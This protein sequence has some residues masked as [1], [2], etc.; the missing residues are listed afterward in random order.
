M[1]LP[2]ITLWYS[3]LGGVST[4]QID[5]LRQSKELV[6]CSQANNIIP[7]PNYAWVT[8]PGFSKVRTN[9]ISGSP[10]ITGLFHGGAL[11]DFLV[12]GNGATGDIAFDTA[13]PPVDNTSGTNF[14]T[15]Q[16]VLLRGDFHEN[17]LIITSNARDLPQTVSA[18]SARADLGGTPPR[19]ID[20]K[21][22]GRRGI[23]FSPSLAGTTYR[24]I[25]SYN[26]ANDDHDAWTNPVTVNYLNFGKYEGDA[27]A[28]GGEYFQDHVIG[29]TEKA[30]YPI[31]VTENADRPLALQQ[32]VFSE[33]GGGPPNIHAVVAAND[34]LY[35][36]SR[37][38]DVKMMRGDRSVKS[39][40]YAVQPFLRGLNNDR[41]VY[42]V[43]GWEPKYRCVVWAVSDGS[44]TTNKTLLMLHV[45]TLQFYFRTISRNAFVNRLVSGELRL[46]GGGY[47]GFFYNEFDSST[48]GDLD[49]STSAIDA[50]VMT[51]RHHLGLPGLRKRVMYV[52]VEFDPIG[53]EAVTVQYQ[54]DDSQSWS[55]FADS[56][57]TLSG[58]DSVVKY[59]GIPKTFKKI[60][61]RFRDANS[62]ERF[63]VLRYGFPVPSFVYT[64]RG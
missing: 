44:D 14:T 50:D 32:A 17:L 48:T 55:S 49:D 35:W 4:Q 59:F 64:T 16:N 30:A 31:Y 2:N 41:R 23:M 51:P 28:L 12:I 9:A 1:P 24:Q 10:P 56:P 26:S 20:Y 8:S 13:D 34:H 36:I 45:D 46:V 42:T 58:T 43:G 54:L 29:F 62:G 52:A 37:N 15:G 21:V 22:L 53:S 39:I 38:F 25:A 27:T 33:S 57:L 18:A 6:E 19:G 60:R 5:T 3:L 11:A 63:R 47:T 7:D 61:L 40:G